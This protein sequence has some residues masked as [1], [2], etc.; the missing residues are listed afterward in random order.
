MQH[1]F[2]LPAF[3][4]D[5][6]TTPSP[7]NQR[8]P[9]PLSV[10]PGAI[11]LK[12]RRR[13]KTLRPPDRVAPGNPHSRTG[14][15][16]PGCGGWTS[17]PAPVRISRKRR[18]PLAALAPQPAAPAARTELPERRR[19]DAETHALLRSACVLTSSRANTSSRTGAGSRTLKVPAAWG[20]GKRVVDFATPLLLP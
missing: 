10:L 4:R 5:P 11:G 12:Q 8:V 18:Q 1:H 19:T 14:R 3:I 6:L 9:A 15:E 7:R 17:N 13:V 2:K 20:R 16:I